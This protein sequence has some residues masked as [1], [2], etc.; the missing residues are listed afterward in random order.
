MFSAANQE[1]V[2]LKGKLLCFLMV[3]TKR[4]Y[5]VRFIWV[6]VGEVLLTSRYA[7]SDEVILMIN[8]RKKI[9]IMFQY[10]MLR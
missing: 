10:A 7:M 6:S 1:D 2:V 8:V 4:N 5:Y 3:P 9:I